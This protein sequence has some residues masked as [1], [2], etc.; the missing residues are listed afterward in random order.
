MYIFN[1]TNILEHLW[2]RGEKVNI[3]NRYK[4]NTRYYIDIQEVEMN[5]VHMVYCT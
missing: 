2:F 1:I 4:K 5:S 3:L